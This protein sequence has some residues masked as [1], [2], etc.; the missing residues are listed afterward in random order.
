MFGIWRR[1]KPDVIKWWYVPA[2]LGFQTSTSEFYD[3]IEAELEARELTGMEVKR[4]TYREGG[5]LSA[6]R[7]YLR[8]QRERLVFDVCSTSFGAYWFFSYRMSEI[9]FTLRVWELLVILLFAGCLFLFYVTLFGLVLGVILLLSS[10]LALLLVMRN[11]VAFGLEDLDSAL[12]QFPVVGSIYEIFFRK[13]TYYRDDTRM[14][15]LEIVD[16]I[17]REKIDEVRRANGLEL[18][19]FREATPPSHPSILQM[20][21]DLLRLGR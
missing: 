14:M 7:E 17:I 13:N 1:K 20:V 18:L 12:L 8:M 5:L 21:G 2:P 6:K 9:P 16:E 4:I 3:A 11:S 10:F 19:E 15:Y